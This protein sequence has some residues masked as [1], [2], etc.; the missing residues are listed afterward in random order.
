MDAVT[1]KDEPAMRGM[2]ASE[3]DIPQRVGPVDDPSHDCG[4]AVGNN[5]VQAKF[6]PQLHLI[7]I[8]HIHT[9]RFICDEHIFRAG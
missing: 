6:K 7:P 1:V 9:V 3:N 5:P 4:S 2:S 8:T